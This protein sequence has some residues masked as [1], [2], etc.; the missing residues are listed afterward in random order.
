MNLN[1]ISKAFTQY[2][3]S[4]VWWILLVLGMSNPTSSPVTLRRI[5]IPT[6]DTEINLNIIIKIMHCTSQEIFFLLVGWDFVVLRPL[7]AY[8]TCPG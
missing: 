1:Y 3:M 5:I 4:D 2:L 7:L 8:C 6:L